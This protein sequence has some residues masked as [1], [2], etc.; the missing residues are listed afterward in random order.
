MHMLT[1]FSYMFDKETNEVDVLRKDIQPGSEAPG[2]TWIHATFDYASNT[3][4]DYY[5]VTSTT[6]N[7]ETSKS[8]ATV[9]HRK[10][11]LTRLSTCYIES[12]SSNPLF[13]GIID[14]EDYESIV[15][16]FVTV[17]NNFDLEVESAKNQTIKMDEATMEELEGG[18]QYIV[19]IYDSQ[20]YFDKLG[21]LTT[22]EALDLLP[23]SYPLGMVKYYE[24][25]EFS[26]RTEAYLRY[27]NYEEQDYNALYPL[28]YQIKAGTLTPYLAYEDHQVYLKLVDGDKY[29]C[30][31]LTDFRL[32]KRFDNY[33]YRY[34]YLSID[35]GLAPLVSEEQYNEA[36][37]IIG[38]Y[39]TG[40]AVKFDMICD[41]AYTFNYDLIDAV[42][43]KQ[44][45]IKCEY[46][47]NASNAISSYYINGDG[48][49][50][51]LFFKDIVDEIL[52]ALKDKYYTNFNSPNS[53][54]YFSSSYG[55]REYHEGATENLK[56]YRLGIQNSDD[57]RLYFDINGDFTGFSCRGT[58]L[59]AIFKLDRD[60]DM[61][62]YSC[63]PEDAEYNSYYYI[64]E[65]YPTYFA[66]RD[67]FKNQVKNHQYSKPIGVTIKGPY[68]TETVYESSNPTRFNYLLNKYTLTLDNYD[69][70]I[71]TEY[72]W[73]IYKATNPEENT[74]W[75]QRLNNG[76]ISYPYQFNLDYRCS[77]INDS[78]GVTTLEWYY[79]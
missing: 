8:N 45:E 10:D 7:N 12:M 56:G 46:S 78:T 28:K 76:D 42:Y 47:N 14:D 63:S 50:N 41:S 51:A 13:A 22:R 73:Q 4:G 72:E 79:E 2:Y 70:Y 67:E 23:S 34:T 58:E 17:T 21:K 33:V 75:V 20:T 29:Y 65:I 37:D 57:I 11:G 40:E 25:Q 64:D 5:Y 9:F 48:E 66:F 77:Y 26:D 61:S 16:N 39:Y 49:G 74:I 19:A 18:T 53:G 52:G 24:E 54:V 62:T 27:S 32:M 55:E 15:S 31:S 69:E 36:M 6:Y 35:E 44:S 68:D 60:F 59:S 38:A 3:L 30:Y 43:I 1:A 71:S